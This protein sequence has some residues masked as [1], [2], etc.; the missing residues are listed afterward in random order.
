MYRDNGT[1]KYTGMILLFIMCINVMNV[2]GEC[3]LYEP[4]EGLSRSRDRRPSHKLDCTGT[5]VNVI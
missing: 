1:K 3:K 2:C 4:H 5:L